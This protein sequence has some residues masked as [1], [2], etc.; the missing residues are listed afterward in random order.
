MS[1]G[2]CIRPGKGL[3][4]EFKI[5]EG[6]MM[7]KKKKKPILAMIIFGIV[8]IGSYV[9]LFSQE[10]LVTDTYTKGGW[11][12]AFP[13]LTAFYF[14]F[15]HGTFGSNLLEVIGFEAKKSKK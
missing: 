8:S 11:Y 4:R 12:A 15:V 6:E 2:C 3:I 10:A 5:N 9:A 13:I 14:S 7:S 1:A